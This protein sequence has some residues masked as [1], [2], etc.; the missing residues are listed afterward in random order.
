MKFEFCILRNGITATSVSME[1]FNLDS[2]R[3]WVASSLRMSGQEFNKY[4][5]IG[6]SELM[7]ISATDRLEEMTGTITGT[8]YNIVNKRQIDDSH[9][10]FDLEPYATSRY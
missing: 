4:H 9:L 1:V 6:Y 2:V 7:D 10:E 5:F 3:R 8:V